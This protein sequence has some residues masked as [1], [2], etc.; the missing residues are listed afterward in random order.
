MCTTAAKKLGNT[1][2]LLKTRD[3]VPWM[4]WDD[5]LKLFNSKSDKF[6]KLIIQNPNLREDG[7]YGGINEKGVAY[8]STFVGVAENQVSYIRRPYVRLILEAATA[9]EAV[10]IIKGFNPRIGGNIFVADQN[11]C[12]GIEAVPEQYFVEKITEPMVKTNHF[13]KLPNRNLSFD[14]DPNFEQWSKDHFDRASEL[15]TTANSLEDFKN[16][17]RD[18]KNAEKHT[19]ICTT[20]EEEECCTYSAFIFDTAKIKAYYCQGNPVENEFEEYGF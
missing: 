11:E 8:I 1:W 10:E 7:Y 6:Q 20:K 16:L 5:E 4:R 18:R 19:A 17:L 13:I 12:F 14:T 15:I 3:P 9:H 2:F